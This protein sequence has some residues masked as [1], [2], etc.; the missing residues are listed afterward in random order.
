MK[1]EIDKRCISELEW[2][3]VNV[4]RPWGIE[5]ADSSAFFSLEEGVGYR[6]QVLSHDINY[7]QSVCKQSLNV[8]MQEGMWTLDLD[9]AIHSSNYLSRKASLNCLEESYFM[10][11]VMRFRFKKDFFQKAVIAGK[12]YEHQKTNKYYQYPVTEAKLIGDRYCMDL[13]VIDS[14]CPSSMKP[15]LYVRDY[16]DEWVVHARM[17]PTSWDKEVIKLCN[18]WA[19]T[20]PIP[21]LLS[22]VLLRIPGVKNAL[23]YRGERKEFTDPLLKRINPLACPLVKLPKGET[24]FWEVGVTIR[25]N[26]HE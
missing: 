4:I 9:D 14:R 21:Q 13:H 26:D 15:F 24:F 7:S 17:L 6:H 18:R 2:D 3:G 16:E 20:R 12:A 23:W 5:T 10:D 8:K 19:K 25:R 22:K 1:W 11:F